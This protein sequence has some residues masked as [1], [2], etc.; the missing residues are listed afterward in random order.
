VITEIKS[1]MLCGLIAYKRSKNI[2]E[3]KNETIRSGKLQ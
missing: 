1:K 3:L 2:S